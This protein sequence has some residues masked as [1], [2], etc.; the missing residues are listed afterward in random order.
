MAVGTGEFGFGVDADG[1]PGGGSDGGGGGY[2][3]GGY[4]NRRLVK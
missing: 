1:G 3:Q 2:I 4:C